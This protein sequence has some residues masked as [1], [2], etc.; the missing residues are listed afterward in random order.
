MRFSVYAEN[1]PWRVRL[2]LLRGA[3]IVSSAYVH[4]GTM[5]IT[6]SVK[7]RGAPIWWQEWRA[8]ADQSFFGYQESGQSEA[9]P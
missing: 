4:D 6:V 5:V 1:L 8:A 7:W 9:I 2:A 3:K